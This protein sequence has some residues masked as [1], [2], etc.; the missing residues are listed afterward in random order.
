MTDPPPPRPPGREPNALK[1]LR[2]LTGEIRRPRRAV[3]LRYLDL[4]S[5]DGHLDRDE[6]LRIMQLLLPPQ[7]RGSV[8]RFALM[9]TLS[10]T[11]AV[12]GLAADSAA[13]VIGAMLIAPLMT[14]I[15][16]F[17][18]AVGLGLGRRAVQAAFLVLAGSVWSV[19]Y[20]IV[21]A[22]LLPTVTIGSELLARTRP[23]VRDLI[24]A[25]A[26]G[27]AGAYAT[28]REDVSAAL[29]GVAVAVA[30]VP[31]LA[32]TGVLI[33]AD[34]LVLAEGSALLFITNLLAI[35]VSA[36][37]VLLATGVIPTLRLCL[38][39][40]RI[41]LTAVG[42]LMATVAIAIPLTTRSLDAATSSKQQAEVAATVDEWIGDLQL[43]VDHVTVEGQQ[44]T[45]EL[46]GLD[47]PPQAF[48]LATR[49]VPVLGDDA[50][51]VVR[52][53][54]RAQG[55]ARA[56][57]EPAT[58]P[59][60]V[61]R[62]VLDGWL[63]DLAADGVLLDLVDLDYANGQDDATV[64][65]TVSGPTR[66][67]PDGGLSDEVADAVGADV[68]LVLRYLPTFD[69][70]LNGEPPDD[71]LAR[72][73]SA[74]IGDRAS[75]RAIATS[76]D[77]TNVLVDLGADGTPAGLEALRR[78]ALD[79][80]EGAERVEIRLLPLTVLEIGPDEITPPSLD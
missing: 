7:N 48:D 75:V 51:A 13:V 40:P 30:L 22:R 72:Y 45:V 34:R 18:A 74:W 71:R 24:V 69:P 52:W 43:D 32:A 78:V 2:D 19:V 26:A 4:L 73:V 33:E 37:T 1:R 38:Q 46:T 67:P 60:V 64:T 65:A 21:L 76:I 6:Q 20:A 56:D 9:L 53:D 15:M 5:D 70:G 57:T 31:P 10:V 23:D 11:I 63:A 49:L 68:V 50:E 42:I 59:A 12:M 27:A 58:D 61:A 77:G 39:S 3:D 54:Q 55:Q 25:V 17:S 66:P 62:A 28:A 29:P 14:P 16:T 79:A 80:V 8:V 44:V 36:L 47:E 41:A 35:I